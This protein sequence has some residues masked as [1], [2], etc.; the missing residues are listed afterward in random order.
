MTNALTPLEEPFSA[1]VNAALARYPRQ[2]GYLLTLFRT[3]ANSVRFLE[4]CVPNL[5]DKESPLD[6]RTREI[7]ILRVTA[8][9]NCE[10]EWGVHVAIFSNA[11]RLSDDQITATRASNADCWSPKERRLISAID[12]LC[13]QGTVDDAALATLQADWT[14]E[15]QLEIIALCGTYSTISMVANVARLQPE[16]FAAT[17]PTKH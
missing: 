10:Y 2:N 3:F 12:Q 1:Q 8:N 13:E 9:R 14:K 4:K 7:I 5:L 6:L 15:E 11:A 17:F 16:N